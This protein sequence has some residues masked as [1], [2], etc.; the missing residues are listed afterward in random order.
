[1]VMDACAQV[2][3]RVTGSLLFEGWAAATVNPSA[4]SSAIFRYQDLVLGAMVEGTVTSVVKTG[5]VVKVGER[6][7]AWVPKMHVADVAIK[8][9][10]A[11]FKVCRC[12]SRFEI[13]LAQILRGF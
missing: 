6:V 4:V 13:Y 1:M 9:L 10:M 5:L 3:C 11:R 12:R 2:S 7:Q 8:D